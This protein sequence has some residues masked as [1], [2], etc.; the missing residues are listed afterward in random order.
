M[1]KRKLIEITPA[2]FQKFDQL[3]DKLRKRGLRVPSM[4]FLVQ[5]AIDRGIE[6]VISENLPAP[7]SHER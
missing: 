6:S 7:V 3:R 5:T 2:Q 4:P 1:P